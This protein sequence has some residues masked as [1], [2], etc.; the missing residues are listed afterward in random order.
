MIPSINHM[1][2]RWRSKQHRAGGRAPQN[3]RPATRKTGP[4]KRFG[5]EGE[6]DPALLKDVR[7][8]LEASV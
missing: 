2:R 8:D 7:R 4:A 5:L 1:A 3:R 6:P